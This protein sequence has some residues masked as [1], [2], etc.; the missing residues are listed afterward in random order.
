MR[1]LMKF[2]HTIGAVGLM[3]AMACLVVLLGFLP[4]PAL[5]SEYAMMTAAMGGIV[6]W[7]FL[8]IARADTDRRLAGD[9]PQSRLSQ[10]GLGLGEARHGRVDLR[11]GFYRHSRADAGGG[12]AQCARARRRGGRERTRGIAGRRAQLFMG[13]ARRGRGKCH[14]RHM[15]AASH[16]TSGLIRSKRVSMSAVPDADGS[17]FCPSA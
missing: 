9:R 13:V 12:G 3:G 16:K 15:A 17:H 1:R 5:L 6:T 14:A 4:K 10:R 2:L 11:M 7:I 8:S